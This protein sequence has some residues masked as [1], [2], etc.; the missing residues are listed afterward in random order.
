MPGNVF[1]SDEELVMQLTV[2]FERVISELNSLIIEEV[3]QE[4]LQVNVYDNDQ[5]V[6][7]NVHY[8]RLGKK[9]GLMGAWTASDAQSSYDELVG[10]LAGYIS[11]TI[12]F[13]A[14]KLVYNPE[15]YQHG[16]ESTDRRENIPEYIEAGTDYDFYME[17]RPF[18]D[19]VETM[20]QDG[21]VDTIFERCAR[22]YGFDL[23]KI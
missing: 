19:D 11:S 18:W 12:S 8:E 9:G 13:D 7:G 2:D 20:I 4:A 10:A 23:I 14:G 16:D 15:K 17:P 6:G 1:S 5:H 3:I 21:T 22:A